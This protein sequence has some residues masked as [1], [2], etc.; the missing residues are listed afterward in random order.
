MPLPPLWH[1]KILWVVVFQPQVVAIDQLG[2]ATVG[3]L[4]ILGLYSFS[5]SKYS[6]FLP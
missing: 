4:L 6:V 3:Y 2:S 5:N 1:A